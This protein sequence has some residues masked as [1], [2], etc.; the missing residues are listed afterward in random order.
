MKTIEQEWNN[1]KKIKLFEIAVIDIRTKE[2]DYLVFNLELSMDKLR[3]YHVSLNNEQENSKRLS[4]VE[5]DI[6]RDFSLD[7]NLEELSSIC[8]N[9]I[10][11]SEFYE[12]S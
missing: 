8:E 3:A 10:T 4:F 1:C 6:D 11:H 7:E 12:L 9:A 2:K 5:M